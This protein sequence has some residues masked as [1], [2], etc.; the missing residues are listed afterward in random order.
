MPPSNEN[1]LEARAAASSDPFVFDFLYNDSRRIASYLSQFEGGHLT[2]LVRSAESGQS[3]TEQSGRRFS[4]GAP[5]LGGASDSSENVGSSAKEGMTRT[6]DPYWA[7]ARA[8]LDYLSE[9]H[10]IE[11]DLNGANM[12]RFVLV[13]GKLAVIDMTSMQSI[14]KMPVFNE[15]LAA[16][17]EQQETG[18]PA[19]RNQR[20]A[21]AK[22]APK[23]P[24]ANFPL[25][26]RM[27]LELMPTMPHSIIA[28]IICDTFSTWSTLASEHLVGTAAD[29][30]LKHGV[31]VAGQWNMLGV[32]DAAPDFADGSL[33][34]VETFILGGGDNS[35]ITN[36]AMGLGPAVRMVAGRPGSSFGMTPLLIFRQIGGPQSPG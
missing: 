1:A 6:F 13:T 23:D 21:Q 29:L 27:A 31:K 7:N 28:A 2:Q 17:L 16:H 30:V 12:G 19:S 34:P 4:L 14:W 5:V 25:E 20:R 35:L 15:V 26:M 11:R 8:F 10:L 32:L 33:D 9:H 18:A 36:A 3:T 22:G 24:L